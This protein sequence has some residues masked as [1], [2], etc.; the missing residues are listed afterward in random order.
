MSKWY[1]QK[2]GSRFQLFGRFSDRKR[3]RFAAEAILEGQRLQK[4]GVLPTDTLEAYVKMRLEEY[5]KARAWAGD[6]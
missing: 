1:G 6:R 2:G 3:N 5:D 4:M